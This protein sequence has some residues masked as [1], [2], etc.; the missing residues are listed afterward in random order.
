MTDTNLNC[1]SRIWLTTTSSRQ[2]KIHS[3]VGKERKKERKKDRQTD[4]QTERSSQVLEKN[5][6]VL[7]FIT[8]ITFSYITQVGVWG[9]VACKILRKIQIL[10]FFLKK[11]F[12]K[13]L[14]HPLTLTLTLT[15]PPLILD[16]TYVFRHSHLVRLQNCFVKI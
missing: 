10:N 5:K 8:F 15:S 12:T 14:A 4:R 16:R 6:R 11:N 2:V 1:L 3:G 9:R 7:L 13:I